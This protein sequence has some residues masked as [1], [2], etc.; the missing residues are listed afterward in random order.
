MQQFDEFHK[1]VKKYNLGVEAAKTNHPNRAEGS[2]HTVS[3][4]P[5][6]ATHGIILGAK[7]AALDIKKLL[8]NRKADQ[9]FKSFCSRVST[10]IQALNPESADTIAINDAHQV[11]SLI[12]F[13]SYVISYADRSRPDH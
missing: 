9:A 2:R 12:S 1:K 5:G 3:I 8:E 4:P 10:A 6:G 11:R 7:E 13:M